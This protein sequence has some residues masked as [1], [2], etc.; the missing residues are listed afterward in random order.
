MGSYRVIT[1]IAVF[2]FFVLQP[3]K[4]ALA[5]PFNPWIWS[6]RLVVIF[7]ETN[8]S[9]GYVSQLSALGDDP[10]GLEERDV[11]IISVF[12]DEVSILKPNLRAYSGLRYNTS[13]AALR[14]HLNVPY[15]DFSVFLISKDGVVR[16]QS[17]R[18]LSN[19][20][21]FSKIDEMPMRKE[22][23]VQRKINELSSN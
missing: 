23:I 7:D 6:N 3:L 11:R 5:S 13:A 2:S 22:E 8:H 21:L 1:I 16:H 14:R 15:G 4:D 12:G 10:E 17:K 20:A 9:P 19:D 18:T